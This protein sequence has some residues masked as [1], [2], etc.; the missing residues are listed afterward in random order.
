MTCKDKN[1]PIHGTISTR[2]KTLKVKIVKALADKTAVVEWPRIRKVQ[3]YDRAYHTKS[4]VSV[5][6]PGC[7]SVKQGDQVI[8]AETRKLSKTK[9]FVIMEVLNNGEKA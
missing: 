4:R 2:K 5:H 7:M 6:I 8:I 1:C 9:S 3:K